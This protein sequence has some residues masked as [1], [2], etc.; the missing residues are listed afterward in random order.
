MSHYEDNRPGPES[1]IDEIESDTLV[2]LAA[3]AVHVLSHADLY[4]CPDTAL[5]NTGWLISAILETVNWRE[6]RAFYEEENQRQAEEKEKEHSEK[7]VEA[8]FDPAT[9]DEKRAQL[10]EFISDEDFAAELHTIKYQ[11]KA[12]SNMVK[13]TEERLQRFNALKTK[14]T[15][16]AEGEMS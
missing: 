11:E 3:S 1:P 14:G 13:Q 9:D 5:S 6:K 8:Y 15:E 10:E 4:E 12:F 16:T 7:A 2:E